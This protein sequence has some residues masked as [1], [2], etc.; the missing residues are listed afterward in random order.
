M[1]WMSEFHRKHLCT[2]ES[3]LTQEQ[4][5]LFVVHWND[6]R[7]KLGAD[8]EGGM[9]KSILEADKILGCKLPTKRQNIPAPKKDGDKFAEYHGLAEV[10][11][12]KED[13][14]ILLE[15]LKYYGRDVNIVDMLDLFKTIHK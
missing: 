10:P 7:S 13:M 14:T 2:I 3:N 4:N 15:I 9:T 8:L 11:A 5:D 12:S 1:R 6:S